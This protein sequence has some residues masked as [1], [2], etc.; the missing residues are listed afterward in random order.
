MIHFVHGSP[1]LIAHGCIV[2]V[3]S[4]D[5]VHLGHQAIIRTM[6][7]MGRQLSLPLLVAS[8]DPHPRSV[9]TGE[10][11]RKLTTLSERSARLAELGVAAFV[12]L[13][14]DREF[15]RMEAAAF[16]E[17]ILSG[18]LRAEGIVLGHDHRFGKDRKGDASL[19]AALADRLGYR[20][21]EVGPVDIAGSVV[22]SSRI[23]GSLDEG[24]V[25]GV[26]SLLGAFHAVS[27]LVVHGAGRGRTIGVPTANLKLTD[28]QKLIPARGVYAVRVHLPD[29][30]TPRAG[31]MNIGHRPTFDGQK[32]HLE[33]NV[34]DWSGDL[35]G[36]EVRV[37]FVERVRDER[38]FD[39]VDAL[40][41]QLNADRDRCRQLL[42]PWV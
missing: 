18:V 38:K 7:D 32:T 29:D 15:A 26:R 34:L 17:D 10:P 3:G 33:V 5:G 21:L 30:G 1:S 37:E 12:C 11:E 28:P 31:M 42:S 22:S 40:I 6:A 8:F 14:F 13:P 39:G 41:R 4:F 36:R 19:L 25:A 2:S 20:F 23:R 24:D 27:G 9:L 35:Y 16:V